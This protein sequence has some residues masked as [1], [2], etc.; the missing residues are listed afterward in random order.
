MS[1][2]IRAQM[3]DQISPT[4]PQ[5]K[6]VQDT[7]DDWGVSPGWNGNGAW[8]MAGS[9]WLSEAE[10]KAARQ[11]PAAAPEVPRP[12]QPA[13]EGRDALPRTEPQTEAPQ[14]GN[15]AFEPL[16]QFLREARAEGK[17]TVLRSQVGGVLAKDKAVY[18]DAGVK[19][20]GEYIA[21]AVA[22]DLVAVG[23]EGGKEWVRLRS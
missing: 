16:L 18:K 8:E 22:R 20:F 21:L 7:N 11:K 17:T 13:A 19:G 3:L 5:A 1:S 2:D 4:P 9:S 10:Q 15:S 14:I 23:G 12:I 6:E